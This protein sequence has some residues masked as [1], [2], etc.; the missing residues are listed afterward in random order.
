MY[1][2]IICCVILQCTI[3]LIHRVNAPQMYGMYLLR[4]EEL[5]S[6]PEYL[7]QEIILYHVT[8]KSRAMES[9]KSGLDWRRTRRSKYGRGVSFSDDADYANYYA[10]DY[11]PDEG[12][13]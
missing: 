1:H 6:T 12:I 8:I 13:I 5:Q 2:Y 11:L 9:L 3:N 7:F 10:A 4:K